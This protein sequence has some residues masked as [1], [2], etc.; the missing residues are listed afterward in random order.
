[1][2]SAHSLSLQT[3][4]GGHLLHGWQVGEAGFDE[5]VR[6]RLLETLMKELLIQLFVKWT[7]PAANGKTCTQAVHLTVAG[8][9]DIIC[10]P[11]LPLYVLQMAHPA[12]P[13]H[14]NKH[15]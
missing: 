3:S 4:Y 15:T 9:A 14:H 10:P 12:E 2:Q 7:G 6:H 1:M 11:S 13:I 8:E 5:L